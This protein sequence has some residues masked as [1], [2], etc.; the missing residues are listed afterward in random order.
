MKAFSLLVL[1]IFARAPIPEKPVGWHYSDE[2][3][4]ASACGAIELQV[5]T[6]S[7]LFIEFSNKKFLIG[8]LRSSVFR[9]DFELIIILLKNYTLLNHLFTFF[10]EWINW[11]QKIV[12][13]HGRVSWKWP[14]IMGQMSISGMR[15]LKEL[16]SLQILVKINFNSHAVWRDNEFSHKI[17][18][19]NII[20]V[21]RHEAWKQ[22]SFKLLRLHQW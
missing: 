8:F 15:F 19:T 6:F 11:V 14:N 18:K 5:W 7:H 2:N 4:S 10:C 22:A 3:D 9:K 1:P 12:K 21:L 20:Y 17:W 13:T 16:N